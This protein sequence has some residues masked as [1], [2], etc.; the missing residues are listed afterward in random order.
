MKKEILKM[1]LE[2]TVFNLE[3]TQ[4]K[5]ANMNKIKA[6]IEGNNSETFHSIHLKLVKRHNIHTFSVKINF[7]KQSFKVES[8]PF[9]FDLNDNKNQ[10]KETFEALLSFINESDMK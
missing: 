8:S 7:W 5:F 4:R 2:G 1:W 10:N 9:V 3:E 6:T